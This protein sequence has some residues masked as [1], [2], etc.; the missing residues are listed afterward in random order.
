MA[1]LRVFISHFA[2]KSHS[3][4]GNQRHFMV[5]GGP[6]AVSADSI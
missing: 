6:V 1:V 5:S 4:K 2:K 3:T